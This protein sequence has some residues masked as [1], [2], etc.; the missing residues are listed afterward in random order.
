MTHINQRVS[1]L[2]KNARILKRFLK[3]I[4]DLF[5]QHIMMKSSRFNEY[6]N[7]EENII[8]YVRNLFRLKKLKKETNDTAIK[9]IK[10][11][12]RLKKRK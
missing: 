4:I 8:K 11:L 1:V 5:S 2:L 9:G 7:M 10:N 6:K 12:F 3:S